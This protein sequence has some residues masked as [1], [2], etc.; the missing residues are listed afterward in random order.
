[1]VVIEGLK[2]VVMQVQC[3]KTRT[4]GLHSRFISQQTILFGE[5]EDASVPG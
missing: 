2:V 5:L 1:M 4:S 3:S